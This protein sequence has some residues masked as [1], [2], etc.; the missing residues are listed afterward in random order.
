MIL[1]VGC[2]RRKL[3]GSVGFDISKDSDADVFGDAEV[4]PWSFKSESFDLVYSSHFLEHCKEPFIVLREMFR[5]CRY[6]G[7]VRVVVPHFSSSGGFNDLSHKH[8]FGYFS[9]EQFGSQFKGYRSQGVK[10]FG[11]LKTHLVFGRFYQMVG[12]DWLANLFPMVY[13]NFFAFIFPCRE[14]VYSFIKVGE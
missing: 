1:D 8:F 14:V 7:E 10:P 5:V 4:T 12:L 3:S 13:E 11:V 2:G 6:G 9:L